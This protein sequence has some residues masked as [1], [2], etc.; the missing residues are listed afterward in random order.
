MLLCCMYMYA[1]QPAATCTLLSLLLYYRVCLFHAL[2][3]ALM[4]SRDTIVEML[5]FHSEHNN[6]KAHRPRY[7]H[8]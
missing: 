1:A 8:D 2:T 4:L 5:H 3:A 7:N 6:T